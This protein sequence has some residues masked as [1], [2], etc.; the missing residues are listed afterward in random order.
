M[1]IVRRVIH[2][3]A[4][5]SA[6]CTNV[7][8]QV[9]FYNQRTVNHGI[10]AK[11]RPDADTILRIVKEFVETGEA[12]RLGFKNPNDLRRSF[13]EFF[14]VEVQPYIGDGVAYLKRTQKGRQWIANLYHHL[15][16]NDSDPAYDP[17]IRA[18]ELV[19]N[20]VH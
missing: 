15:H 5:I 19:V 6:L 13:P 20:N 8:N 12:T 17:K 11:V 4:D 1:D 7:I 10:S 9:V 3:N 16:I 2:I 18:P 14:Y